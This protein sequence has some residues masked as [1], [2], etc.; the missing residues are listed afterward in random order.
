MG[1]RTPDPTRSVAFAG[2][3]RRRRWSTTGPPVWITLS[4]VG[5][6][7]VLALAWP[8]AVAPAAAETDPDRTRVLLLGDSLMDEAGPNA[9]ERLRAAGYDVRLEATPGS[10]LLA[11]YVPDDWLGRMRQLID[12]Y[13]PDIVVVEFC[14]NHWPGHQ[15]ESNPY[16]LLKGGTPEFFLAWEGQVDRAVQTLT[17]RGA[18]LSWV[19]TPPARNPHTNDVVTGLNEIAIRASRRYG[20]EMVNWSFWLAPHGHFVDELPGRGRIRSADGLHLAPSGAE[21]VGDVTADFVM[22]TV[23]NFRGLPGAYY[24]PAVQWAYDAGLT[25]GDGSTGRF[26]PDRPVTRAEA[27]T[28]LWRV[29]GHP[30]DTRIAFDDVQPGAFYAAAAAWGADVGVTTG[31][32]GSSLFEPNRPVTRAEAVTFIHRAAGGPGADGPLLSDVPAD[33]Y[34]AAA[35]RWALQTDVTTGV[36]GTGRF[37]PDRAVTRAELVTF[38]HRFSHL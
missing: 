23:T 4:V 28:F 33:A 19:V 11:S 17:S 7:L 35:V 22:S 37:E 29:N 12:D 21:L 31:V 30:H 15:P 16:R 34:Y 6:A 18:V 26:M 8:A 5:L 2:R 10:G 38:L 20:F 1:A 25:T 13:N 27:I 14:C 9:A 3:A 36:G 32:G 24:L